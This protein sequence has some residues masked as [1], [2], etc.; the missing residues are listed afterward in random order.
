MNELSWLVEH[1]F[2][3]VTRREYDW[4]FVF[5]KNITLTVECLWRLVENGRIR[6][7]SQDEGQEFGLP[8]PVNA[9]QEINC[10][11]A[12]TSITAVELREGLLDLQLHFTSSHVLQ[13]TPDSSGYEAW[14]LSDGVRLF[15]AVG[16]GELVIAGGPQPDGS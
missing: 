6:V 16:G 13:I 12:Q 5:D 2:Q 4:V 15:I 10:R 11:L 9:V 8:T 3:S 7:T 14:E 1:R